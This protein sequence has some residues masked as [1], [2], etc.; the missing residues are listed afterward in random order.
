MWNIKASVQ[1]HAH[2]LPFISPSL[3]HTDTGKYSC[4]AVTFFLPCV[5]KKYKKKSNKGDWESMLGHWNIS[6]VFSPVSRAVWTNRT[7]KGIKNRVCGQR[8]ISYCRNY[9]GKL[10]LNPFQIR[11]LLCLTWRAIFNSYIR[12]HHT[13]HWKLKGPHGVQNL[14]SQAIC[15]MEWGVIVCRI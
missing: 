11:T 14:E 15:F 7:L 12:P 10:W 8:H 1:S 13:Y 4:I 5:G 9:A 3:S 6:S 2:T